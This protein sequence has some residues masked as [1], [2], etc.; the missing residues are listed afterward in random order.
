MFFY[1]LVSLSLLFALLLHLIFS[2][3]NRDIGR[4]IF[5][6]VLTYGSLYSALKIF[7]H[8]NEPN[9]GISV[10]LA[11]GGTLGLI[12]GCYFGYQAC[13]LAGLFDGVG[14]IESSTI[15]VTITLMS[16]IVCLQI[17]SFFGNVL[18]SR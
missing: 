2:S 10:G 5:I 8:R 6:Y 17:G 14:P 11:I 13:I 15:T 18:L 1:F 7:K 12:A 9:Y 4:S 3:P 16:G